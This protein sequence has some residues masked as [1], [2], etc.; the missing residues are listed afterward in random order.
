[1]KGYKAFLPNMMTQHG[2]DT[3]YEVGKTYTVEGEIKICENGYHPANDITHK[4]PVTIA[5]LVERMRD[6]LDDD[7]D[8]TAWVFSELSHIAD[9][10]EKLG[11]SNA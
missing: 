8:M 9:Q 4:K 1:M 6:V 5:S 7:D 10:L 3:V 2:D 11:D